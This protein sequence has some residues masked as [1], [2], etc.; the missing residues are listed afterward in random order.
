MSRSSLVSAVVSYSVR[1]WM[2]G[3]AVALFVPMSWAAL[4]V[5]VAL[6]LDDPLSA[7]VL[8]AS[9]RLEAALDVHGGRTRIEV[10]DETRPA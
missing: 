2:A 7:R 10:A 3:L 8:D 6:G 5:D 4:A 1:V 9:A